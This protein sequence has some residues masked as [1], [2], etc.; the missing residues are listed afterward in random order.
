MQDPFAEIRRVIEK[1][2]E[3]M[4]RI[5]VTLQNILAPVAPAIVELSKQFKKGDL[6]SKALMSA[7]WLP[8]YTTPFQYIEEQADDV[9]AVRTALIDYYT[10]NWRVVR[11][12][13]DS[14]LDSYSIDKE[15]KAA[16]RESLDAHE[17]GLYRCVCRVLFPEVDRLLYAVVVN[18]ED[19][20]ISFKDRIEK[21]INQAGSRVSFYGFFYDLDMFHYL[22]NEQPD[23]PSSDGAK[24]IYGLFAQV[25][26]E[27][28]LQHLKHDPV[29]NRHAAMHGLVSYSSQQNSLN[30]I[31]MADYF[32]Q[33]IDQIAVSGGAAA[34]DGPVSAALLEEH[35]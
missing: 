23:T 26:T 10:E 6:N 7:G 16:F 28:Q 5:E 11:S 32:F 27:K 12:Q 15:A 35:N 31:F 22:T 9:E 13:I 24:L 3:S 14:Q 20:R 34:N 4:S 2:Q 30:A 29:P 1:W 17:A 18:D 8:H 25:R 19:G 21:L 33:M